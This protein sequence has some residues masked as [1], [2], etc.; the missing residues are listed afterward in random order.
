MPG[1]AVVGVMGS[2]GSGKTTLFELITGSNRPDAGSVRVIGANIHDVKYAE[3]DRLD[4]DE[5]RIGL[6]GV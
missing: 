2:N 1:A 6:L 5:L 4:D 3:R